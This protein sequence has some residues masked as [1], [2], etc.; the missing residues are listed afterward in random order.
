MRTTLWSHALERPKLGD[1]FDAITL[2]ELAEEP[3]DEKLV[4]E[5]QLANL[6]AHGMPM[7][8]ALDV[9]PELAA[10]KARLRRRF[11]DL[12][13]TPSFSTVHDLRPPS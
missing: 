13:V 7:E 1:A 5:L 6:V 3:I 11:P 12:V 2:D 8:E 4:E 10:K 9:V